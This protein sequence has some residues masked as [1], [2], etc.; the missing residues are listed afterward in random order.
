MLSYFSRELGKDA[1]PKQ[2]PADFILEA[3]GAGIP[4]IQSTDQVSEDK[5]EIDGEGEGEGEGE[6]KELEQ[7]ALG[8]N[9]PVVVTYKNSKLFAN[10]QKILEQEKLD[11]AREAQQTKKKSGAVYLGKKLMKRLVGRYSTTFW[12]QLRYVLTRNLMAYWRDP[13]QFKA[14]LF[15]YVS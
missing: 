8:E 2:N 7:A 6:S 13:E 4:K 15:M 11:I 12:T 3:V 9:D 5:E 1:D 14:R 10:T